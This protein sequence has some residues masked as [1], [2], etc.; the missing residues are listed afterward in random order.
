[1]G[2]VKRTSLVILGYTALLPIMHLSGLHI[3]DWLWWLQVIAA[4]LFISAGEIEV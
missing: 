4:I 2:W 1:M 3:S